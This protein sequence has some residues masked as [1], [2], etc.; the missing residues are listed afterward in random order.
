MSA[1]PIATSRMLFET[2]YGKTIKASPHSNGTTAR[3]FRPY[4]RKPNPIDPNNNPQRSDDAFNDPR[5]SSPPY[6]FSGKPIAR[7]S[8]RPAILET[9]T[10][11]PIALHSTTTVVLSSGNSDREVLKP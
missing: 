8:I 6:F 4:M 10:S 5:S 9:P 7:R 11:L 1:T 3:C 2:K